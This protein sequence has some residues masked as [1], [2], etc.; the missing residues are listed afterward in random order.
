MIEALEAGLPVDL[1]QVSAE[2]FLLSFIHC[3][4]CREAFLNLKKMFQL[5]FL[6]L[7]LLL[8]IG[9]PWEIGLLSLGKGSH[10]RVVPP[11]LLSMFF[12][13]TVETN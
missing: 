1:A 13:T 3:W 10:D 8:G 6:H 12:L 7:I 4:Q 5:Y 9:F 2:M 11:S